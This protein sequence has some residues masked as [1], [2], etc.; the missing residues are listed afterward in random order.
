MEFPLKL[1]RVAGYRLGRGGGEGGLGGGDRIMSGVQEG[2]CGEE[3]VHKCSTSLHS[4]FCCASVSLARLNASSSIPDALDRCLCNQL[5]GL[6][7][8]FKSVSSQGRC[9]LV[10]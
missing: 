8:I 9:C 6:C 2:L 7:W 3:A 10:A 4:E 1:M 5:K